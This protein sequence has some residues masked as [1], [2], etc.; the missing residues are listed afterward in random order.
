[1]VGA[2]SREGTR[3]PGFLGALLDLGYQRGHDLYVVNPRATEVRGVPSYPTVL[4]CP[5]PL[6]H[7]ISLIPRDG[8]QELLRQCVQKGVRSVHFFTAGFS[9]SGDEA[10]AAVERAMAAEAAAAGVRM[11][12]PNCMGIYVPS[13][14]VSW[15]LNVPREPGGVFALSQSGVNAGAI[16]SELAERG[17]RFSKVVSFGNGADIAAPELLDYAAADPETQ[18]VVG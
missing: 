1:M 13:E 11:L 5:D 16:I 18:V 6:D 3:T 8:A 9:E 7:V 15:T 4:D 17:V 12:G 10:M 2:S 14:Q